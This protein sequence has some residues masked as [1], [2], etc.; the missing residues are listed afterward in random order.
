MSNVKVDAGACGFKAEIEAVS[1]DIQRVKVDI[2]TDCPNF[3]EFIEEIKVVNPYDEIEPDLKKWE[4]P[5]SVAKISSL[6]RLPGSIRN[7][8]GSG[9]GSRVRFAKR[10]KHKGNKVVLN[11]FLH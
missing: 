2:S 3:A 5:K 10:C 9:N 11:S 4:N 7:Y 1:E 8:K 6:F